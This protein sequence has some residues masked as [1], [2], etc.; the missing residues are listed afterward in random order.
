MALQS[1]ASYTYSDTTAQTTGVMKMDLEAVIDSQDPTDL[2]LR[3]F[4]GYNSFVAVNF[5]HEFAE[6]NAPPIKAAIGT[7]A[8]GWN[9][10]DDT[11]LISVDDSDKF[12]LGDVCLTA[13]GEI[14]IVSAVGT[15]T[16]SVL[17]RGDCGSTQSNANT[18]ADAI[19]LIGNAQLEGYTPGSYMR[20]Y[21][22]VRKY[23]Y[24]QEWNEDVSVT[25]R[26]QGTAQYSIADEYAHQL[27]M[28]TLRIAKLLEQAVLLGGA[29]AG[30]ATNPSTMQG[31]IG[32]GTT[33]TNINIQT[34][35]TNASSADLTED[36]IQDAMQSC[37]TQGGT[38]NTIIC[39]AFQKRQLDTFMLPYR[40][41]TMESK[42]YG[43]V[44]DTYHST[45]GTVEVLMDRYMQNDDMVIL[46]KKQM[47]IGSFNKKSFSHYKLPKTKTIEQGYVNG[48]YTVM[49]HNEE[50]AAWIYGLSTS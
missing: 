30:D 42:T 32:P 8:T 37:Y 44:V 40:R 22:R 7:A 24:C 49:L 45:F 20:F 2:P 28:K 25:D 50:W 3:Q 13:D 46:D 16:I 18:D 5:K 33:S 4:L 11:T 27:E 12:V 29:Q 31:V 47:E 21:D 10:A 35:T 9:T 41:T 17:A 6:E 26:M 39:G 23:N 36:T 14:V 38:P 48:S 43:G 1:G 15:N 19:Y 34:N